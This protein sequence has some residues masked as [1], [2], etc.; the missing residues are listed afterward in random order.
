MSQLI[1]VVRAFRARRRESV[2]HTVPLF[3]RYASAAPLKTTP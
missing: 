2:R 1:A 3:V